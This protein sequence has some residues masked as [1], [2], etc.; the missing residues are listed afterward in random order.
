MLLTERRSAIVFLSRPS[1]P[2]LLFQM[3]PLSPG[4]SAAGVSRGVKA[5]LGLTQSV[6]ECSVVVHGD[7]GMVL[8]IPQYCSGP[9]P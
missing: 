9:L 7:P 4:Q 1:L 3:P 2:Q 8:L 5:E 6:A